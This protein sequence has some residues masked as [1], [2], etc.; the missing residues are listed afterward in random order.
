MGVGGGGEELHAKPNVF[1]IC[2]HLRENQVC[3]IPEIWGRLN[4]KV[5]FSASLSA[6][7]GSI[8]QAFPLL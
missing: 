5:G 3:L 7:T 2:F 1:E 8:G 4:G 6:G